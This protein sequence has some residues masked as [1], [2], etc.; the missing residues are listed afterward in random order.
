MF[1][2][3]EKTLPMDIVSQLFFGVIADIDNTCNKKTSIFLRFRILVNISLLL[4]LP[5]IY[6]L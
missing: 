3:K 1:E 5:I 2:G 6:I 4:I